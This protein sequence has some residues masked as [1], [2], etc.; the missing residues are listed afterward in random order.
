MGVHS[1]PNQVFTQIKL[2]ATEGSVD[3]EKREF[4]VNVI[5]TLARIQNSIKIDPA[6]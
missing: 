4:K 3:S 5:K 2:A 6:E 1:R